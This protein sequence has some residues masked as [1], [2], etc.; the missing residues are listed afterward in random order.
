MWRDRWLRHADL[1][2]RFGQIRPLF[3]L[4]ALVLVASLILG[5]STRAGFLSDTLLQLIAIPL[6]LLA[7]WQVIRN[8]PYP[9]GSARPSLLL[10]ACRPSAPS[11]GSVAALALGITATIEHPRRNSLRSC[12]RTRLGCQLASRRTRPG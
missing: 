4:C 9:A 5:V 6:L 11:I 7:L 1:A 12:S 2:R 10:G 3:L 8:S